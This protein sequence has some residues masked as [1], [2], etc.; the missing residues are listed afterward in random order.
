MFKFRLQ[1]ILELREQK[2]KAQA[3]E[4]ASAQHTAELAAQTQEMIAAIREDS[5]QQV[6]AATESAPRVGHLHQ[7]DSVLNALDAR[8]IDAT[9]AVVAAESTVA[10]AQQLLADAAR[11][12]KVLD[13]LKSRHA[14]AWRADEAQK[15]RLS[16]D[17]I[18]LTRFTRQHDV[19][20]GD[21][22]GA[23]PS[24]GPAR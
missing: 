20:S 17:E 14:D 24:D 11:D 12:R 10:A 18:A 1:R 9:D 4:L 16:M 19:T 21:A 7:F 6:Q 3:R 22:A 23:P 2:E 15:D 8:L 5:R 13:R